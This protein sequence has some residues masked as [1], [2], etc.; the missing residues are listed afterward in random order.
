MSSFDSLHSL[1]TKRLYALLNVYFSVRIEFL[2]GAIPELWVMAVRSSSYFDGL[3]SSVVWPCWDSAQC[4]SHDV[5]RKR[6]HLYSRLARSRQHD[7]HLVI[8]TEQPAAIRGSSWDAAGHHLYRA[9]SGKFYLIL[10]KLNSLSE[11]K[12]IAFDYLWFSY[13][14]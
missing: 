7:D 6:L 2:D 3:R 13:A 5:A 9:S 10:Y 8:T 1:L 11:A 12:L 14:T 4:N